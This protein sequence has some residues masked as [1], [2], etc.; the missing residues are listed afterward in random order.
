MKLIT[1]IYL[2]EL[3]LKYQSND[4]NQL[5]IVFVTDH[6]QQKKLDDTN[7]SNNYFFI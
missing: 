1:Q 7:V 6:L 4:C 5:Q 3:S 2:L